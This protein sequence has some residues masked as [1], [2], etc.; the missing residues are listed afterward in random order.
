MKREYWYGLL[1]FSNNVGRWDESEHK[2]F[3]EGLEKY[4]NDWKQIANMVYLFL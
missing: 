2:L 1:H 4:G 3:L